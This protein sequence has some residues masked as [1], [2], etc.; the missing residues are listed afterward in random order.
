MSLIFIAIICVTRLGFEPS[1]YIS[2]Y[3]DYQLFPYSF[4]LFTCYIVR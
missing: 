3:I 1:S 2:A 4:G